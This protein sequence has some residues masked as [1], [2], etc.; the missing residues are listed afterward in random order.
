MAIDLI[1]RHEWGARAPRSAYTYLTS[2]RGVKVHY[3]GGSVDPGIVRDHDICVALVKAFQ[4]Q[5]MDS[6]GWIDLGYSMVACPHRQVFEGRGPH[7][8]PSANGAGL[9]TG[10]YAVL[11]LVGNAGFTQPNDG[12]LWGILDAVAYLRSKGAA[13]NDLKG[14]RDGYGTDCP[15]GPLYDWVR[16]GC[17]APATSGK[18]ATPAPSKPAT[19][20][21]SGRLLMYV[22]GRPLMRGA[23]VEDWQTTLKRLDYVLTADGLYGEHTAA[24]T[25]RFQKDAR[26]AVDGIVGPDTSKKAAA[27]LAARRL[28]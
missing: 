15:G 27:E 13:G 28:R 23:D 14:H 12:V 7:H 3:T 24:M 5:H 9:N 21:A 4:R 1:T 20:S 2:T 8:L 18:P 19:P 16:R 22:Q 11:G 10:H 17:P 26:L 25:R 6:N